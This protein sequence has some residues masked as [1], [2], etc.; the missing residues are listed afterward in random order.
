MKAVILTHIL[1]SFDRWIL[2]PSTLLRFHHIDEPR[3]EYWLQ[4]VYTL[5]LLQKLPDQLR[6]GLV[7]QSFGFDNRKKSVVARECFWGFFSSDQRKAA[8]PVD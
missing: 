2:T 6:P 8:L 7:F 3:V 1:A 4:L 5:T